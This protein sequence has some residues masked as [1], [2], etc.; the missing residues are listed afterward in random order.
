MEKCKPMILQYIRH[1]KTNARVGVLV[2]KVIS[3]SASAMK[4]GFGWS[5]CYGGFNDAV[6]NA[7]LG[8]IEMR[9]V[10]GDLFNRE[11][12][13]EIAEGRAEKGTD[14]N[15][16][17]TLVKKALPAFVQRAVRYFDVQIPEQEK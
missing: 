17:H 16:S 5:M 2:A 3:Q 4:I 13:I 15:K 9:K 7:K 10:G 8:H 1:P 11:R 12:G 6:Y 14:F